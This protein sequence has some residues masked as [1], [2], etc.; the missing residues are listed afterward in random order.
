MD[1]TKEERANWRD[2]LWCHGG[3]ESPLREERCHLGGE[4]LERLLND[5]D[6][7][8]SMEGVVAYLK[9]MSEEDL[10]REDLM[11]M[12]AN[13]AKDC[14]DRGH[15]VAALETENSK[16]KQQIYRMELEAKDRKV[17]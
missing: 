5:A 14:V 13:S 10:S 16:L 15:E 17:S 1:T 12:M 6:R 3:K 7:H 9:S 2:S 4:D 11:L 8:E